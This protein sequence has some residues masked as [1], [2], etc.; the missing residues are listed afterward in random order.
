MLGKSKSIS[1]KLPI[2]ITFFFHSLFGLFFLIIFLFA[3]RNAMGMP[4]KPTKIVFADQIKT[5]NCILMIWIRHKNNLLPT[6]QHH[7][8]EYS[9]VQYNTFRRHMMILMLNIYP[10]T[11]W[12]YVVIIMRDKNQLELAQNLVIFVSSVH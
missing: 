10:K 9:T 6:K 4:L 2:F 5:I 1:Y 7:T 12:S 3:N 8:V 11:R